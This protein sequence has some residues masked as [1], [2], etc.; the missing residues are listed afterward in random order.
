MQRWPTE[1][2]SSW[3]SAIQDKLSLRPPGIGLAWL[4]LSRHR[5][6][7]PVEPTRLVHLAMCMPREFFL[8]TAEEELLP[9]SRLLLEARGHPKHGT[10]TPSWRRGPSSHP[11]S[12]SLPSVDE[13]MN[14]DW[15]SREVREEF[16]LGLL[17]CSPQQRDFRNGPRR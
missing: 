8:G 3:A 15:L 16:C 7:I 13:L 17:G 9:L 4:Y 1:P 6:T 5:L 14:T 11:R 12:R 2:S 10:C